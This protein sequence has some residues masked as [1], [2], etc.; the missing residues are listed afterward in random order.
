MVVHGPN[1]LLVPIREFLPTPAD[2]I[3]RAHARSGRGLAGAAF[4]TVYP[5]QT[6]TPGRRYRVK[7]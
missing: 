6:R 1:I 5:G 2:S 4:F 3:V 7:Q